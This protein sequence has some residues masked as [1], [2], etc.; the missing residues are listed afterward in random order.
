MPP[1]YS[2]II[3]AYNEGA[4]LGASLERVV[5]YIHTQGWNAEVVVVNDGS[6]D[7]T[8]GIIR[9]FAAK[10][11]IVRLIENPGNRG[12]GYSVRNGML[13]AVGEILIF[14]DADLSSPI[15]ESSKLLEA[16][17]QGADVAIGSR[18]LR[19][20]TQTQRQ[21]LH[22]QIF[23]RIFNLLL[24]L[25]LGLQF[26][27]TQCGFKAFKRSA[28]QA[29]FPL[30]KIERWG[31]DPEILFLARKLGFK[32]KEVPVLWGHSGGTRIHPLVDGSRMFTEMLRVRWYSLTGKYDG[33]VP[34]AAEHAKT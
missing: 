31:F 28:A 5:T 13:R 17:N 16:L 4:R 22:R 10:Y 14:S 23:G 25:A 29:I 11:P 12:K 6:R 8:A 21:P 33:A 30:Q 26:K 19:T 15:E 24:R 20:E 3:P 1:K 7:H 32:V 2:I 18:W 34:A 9:A 27:D